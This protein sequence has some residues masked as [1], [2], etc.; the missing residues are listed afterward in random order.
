MHELGPIDGPLLAFGGPFGNLEAT[1]ALHAAARR[2]GIPPERVLCTGDIVAYCA[3]PQATVDLLRDWGIVILMG[4]V[5]EAIANAA[6]DCGCGFAS[7]SRCDTLAAAWYAYAAQHVDDATKH[8]MA[9]LP[10]RVG[11][12]LGG[13][14]LVAVHGAVDRINR[15]VFPGTAKAEKTRQLD[16]AGADGVI[17]GHSGLPFS[18]RLGARL[19]HNPGAIGLPANDGTPRVWYSLLRPTREGIVVEHRALDYDHARAARRIREAGLPADYATALENGLWPS[20][21]IMP[22]A[23]RARRGIALME[24]QILWRHTEGETTALPGA[25]E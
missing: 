16:L 19:W 5:E 14:R 7:G 22:A 25:A 8:W 9:G 21:D 15:Y 12:T 23:D 11:L 2:H 17:G 24:T 1:R 4:N 18:E 20:D 13:R 3:D 10:R 6:A